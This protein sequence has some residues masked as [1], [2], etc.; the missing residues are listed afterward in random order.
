M[1]KYTHSHVHVHTCAC[2]WTHTSCMHMNIHIQVH[3]YM[4]IYIYRCSRPPCPRTCSHMQTPK[5]TLSCITHMPLTSMIIAHRKT[6]SK[7]MR[8]GAPP[9]WAGKCGLVKGQ[10]WVEVWMET[11][12]GM[13]KAKPISTLHIC[14]PNLVSCGENALAQS[15]GVSTVTFPLPTYMVTHSWN[16]FSC[17]VK[18]QY[19]TE[20]TKPRW[21]C[22]DTWVTLLRRPDGLVVTSMQSWCGTRWDF[23]W[24]TRAVC[25]GK[26][27][28]E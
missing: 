14:Q 24:S 28:V 17:W 27:T 18:A 15:T 21:P 10:I 19:M 8:V 1:F 7:H 26:R 20:C 22:C 9:M 25:W 6:K 11:G 13:I 4:H 12:L 23:P 3:N 5:Q 16:W 2:T